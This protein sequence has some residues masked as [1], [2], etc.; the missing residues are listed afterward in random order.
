MSN[1]VPDAMLNA[2]LDA[3]FDHMGEQMHV[4]AQDVFDGVEGLGALAALRQHAIR[5]AA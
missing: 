3:V 4:K 1:A 2:V 5:L